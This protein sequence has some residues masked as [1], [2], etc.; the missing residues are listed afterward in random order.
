[1]SLDKASPPRRAALATCVLVVALAA[2]PQVYR[3]EFT[4][5]VMAMIMLWSILAIGQNVIT[6]FCGQLSLG[7]AAFYGIGAYTS[8]LLT[9]RLDLPFPVALVAAGLAAGV[10]GV[11]IGGPAVRIAGDYLFIVTLGFG[12]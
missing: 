11:A 4:L 1:M 8:A 6:G 5:R 7:H 2:L 10:A 9:M 3:N 12:E